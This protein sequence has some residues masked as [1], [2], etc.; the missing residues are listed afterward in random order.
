M[1][2]VL[3]E[4][5]I[6]PH[7]HTQKYMVRMINYM[8]LYSYPAVDIHLFPSLDCEPLVGHVSHFICRSSPCGYHSA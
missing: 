5:F 7:L 4:F 6:M 1:V 3:V 2:F 8:I